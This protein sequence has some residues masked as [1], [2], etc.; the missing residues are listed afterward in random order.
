MR[1]AFAVAMH[2]DPTVLLVDEALAV[3]DA[4]FQQKCV[5]RIAEFRRTGVTLVLVSHD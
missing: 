2:I 3:G 1:L 4:E 5:E